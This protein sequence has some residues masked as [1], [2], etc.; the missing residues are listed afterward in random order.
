MN[1]NIKKYLEKVAND[2]ELV[3][4]LNA[5]KDPEEAYKIASSLQEGFTKEEFFSAMDKMAEDIK[6][7]DLSDEDLKNIAGGGTSEVAISA[8]G[9][10]AVSAIVFGAASAI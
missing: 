3:A 10:A 5:I 4:K 6:N 1:E 7:N 8:A 9:S 2:P